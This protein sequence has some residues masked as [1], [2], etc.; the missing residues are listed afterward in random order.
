M[1]RRS[2]PRATELGAHS[3]DKC[4]NLPVWH[5]PPLDSSQLRA[6]DAWGTRSERPRV[7]VRPAVTLDGVFYGESCKTP[8]RQAGRV[9]IRKQIS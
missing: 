1:F 4:P 3:N 7:A 9:K 5:A 8:V 6:H 2:A